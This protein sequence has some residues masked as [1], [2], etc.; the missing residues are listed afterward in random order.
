MAEKKERKVK[1]PLPSSQKNKGSNNG[2]TRTIPE[3]YLRGTVSIA[4]I[5]RA[6]KNAQQQDSTRKT[7][8]DTIKVTD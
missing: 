2:F 1:S 6:V 7:S 3:P 8:P 5:D 4:K